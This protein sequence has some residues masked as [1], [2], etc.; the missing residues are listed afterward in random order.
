MADDDKP[1]PQTRSSPLPE[2]EKA[3]I[4][5]GPIRKTRITLRPRAVGGHLEPSPAYL[6]KAVVPTP[7]GATSV[8]CGKPTRRTPR[9]GSNRGA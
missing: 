5:G 9:R 2:E 8:W 1:L 4:A 6:A 7:L 3:A